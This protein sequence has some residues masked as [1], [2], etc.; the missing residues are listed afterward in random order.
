VGA[1]CS[2]RGRETPTGRDQF[3]I[4]ALQYSWHSLNERVNAAWCVNK[5]R[6]G[7]NTATQSGVFDIHISAALSPTYGTTNV[8][9]YAWLV[10]ASVY[11]RHLEKFMNIELFSPRHSL[12]TIRHT[13]VCLLTKY[14][15]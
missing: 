3:E 12:H 14:L 11:L 4:L 9:V 10:F 7:G 1:S 8:V 15:P 5:D 2:T 6:T 13:F